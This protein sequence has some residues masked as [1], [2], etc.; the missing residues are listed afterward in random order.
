MS[1][2]FNHRLGLLAGAA[3]IALALG[4]GVARAQDVVTIGLVTKTDSNPFFAK[5][6]EG[7]RTRAGGR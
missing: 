2:R 7:G 4:A 6:R 5:M 1:N 3:T